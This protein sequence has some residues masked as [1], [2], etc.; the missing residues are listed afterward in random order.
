MASDEYEV[1]FGYSLNEFEKKY[2]MKT[3]IIQQHE[4]NTI[5]EIRL[6]LDNKLY[7]DHGTVSAHLK[8]LNLLLKRMGLIA[9]GEERAGMVNWQLKSRIK[10]VEDLC[11]QLM[12]LSTELPTIRLYRSM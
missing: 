6:H 9:F 12:Q 7:R 4:A 3:Y 11:N 8:A 5:D 2:G 10:E 1:E